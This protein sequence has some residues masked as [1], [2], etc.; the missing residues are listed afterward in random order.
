MSGK[1]GAHGPLSGVLAAAVTP[2]TA[3][4]EAIDEPAVLELVNFYVAA[5][6]DGT[7]IAGTTGEGLL[8]TRTERERLAE[9][10]LEA[11]DG[12]L[13][14]T[15]HAGALSTGETVALATHAAA[16]GATAVAVG[17][18]PFFNVDDTSLLAHFQAAAEACAPVPFYLYEIR[19]HAGYA[20]PVP[21]VERLR[22]STTNLVGMK[23]SDPTMEELERY[24]LPGFDI[25][26]GAESL[27]TAG[28]AAGAVGAISGIAAALPQ[29]VVRAL[30]DPNDRGSSVAPLRAGL[31]RYPLQAAAKLALVA[32]NLAIG[33]SVRAPLRGLSP[34]ERT[35]LEDWLAGV[36]IAGEHAPAL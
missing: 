31:E 30:S 14:V 11:A 20:I 9:L 12:R 17:A 35:H 6:L 27:L 21:V 24:L 16:R 25:L 13:P 7:M 22:E 5:G 1:S 32:Q 26:V 29:H 18:P 10:F 33:A 34:A 19:T 15:V 2:F 36:L 4:G 8:L 3:G 28:L 23:V